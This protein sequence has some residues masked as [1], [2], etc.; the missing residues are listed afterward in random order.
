[1]ADMLF[2]LPDEARADLLLEVEVDALAAW[3][4]LLDSDT[5]RR[6]QDGLPDTLRAS[7][8]G[9]SAFPSRERQVALAEQA[10]R[11]LAG[12][13]QRQLARARLSFEA[14]V[15]PRAAGDP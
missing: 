6:I 14:V 9:A 1:V 13:F 5:A 2:A 4:S 10:R 3:L 11:A 15:G 8:S 7:L 12:G